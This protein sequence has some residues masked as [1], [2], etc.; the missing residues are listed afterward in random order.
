MKYRAQITL[1]WGKPHSP[2]DQQAIVAALVDAGWALAETTALIIE[3]SDLGRIW[4]GV[5]VVAKG[6]SAA[7]TLTALSFNVVASDDFGKSRPYAA[8]KNHPN[9][10][11]KLTS[12]PF[13]GPK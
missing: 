7:G 10:L 1:D 2:N 8:I 6:A 5:E 12:L 4:Q 11:D 3:T 9:A 13:P